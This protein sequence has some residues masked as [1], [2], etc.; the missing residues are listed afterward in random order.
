MRRAGSNR[1][2]RP[3]FGVGRGRGEIQLAALHLRQQ[4][5]V[6]DTF[7]ETHVLPVGVSLRLLAADEV[8]DA[9]ERNLE[10]PVLAPLGAGKEFRVGGQEVVRAPEL[11]PLVVAVR[12]CPHVEPPEG[13]WSPGRTLCGRATAEEGRPAQ[14]LGE[15]V[16][17]VGGD[18]QIEVVR[19]AGEPVEPDGVSAHH[20]ARQANGLER[21]DDLPEP[22][23]RGHRRS[24]SRGRLPRVR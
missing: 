12:E 6:E 1:R 4:P 3:G 16:P 13:V 9:E 21:S 8:L 24:S 19:V 17:L 11:E 10:G 14:P 5:R 22:L 2:T 18:V 7:Q 23:L 15:V 20:Q